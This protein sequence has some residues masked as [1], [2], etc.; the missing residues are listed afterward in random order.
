[1]AVAG[2]SVEVLVIGMLVVGELGGVANVLTGEIVGIGVNV[3]ADV[4]IISVS[5]LVIALL[6]SR[7]VDVQ[8]DTVFDALPDMLADVTIAVVPG[9]GVDVLIDA[10]KNVFEA[11]TIA[12]ELAM[13]APWEELGC[14]SAFA[15][16]PV[17]ALSCD[18][19]LQTRM[20][21][22]QVC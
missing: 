15:R 18:R 9:F 21:S 17:A 12:S 5:K 16:A 3:A 22:Y 7:S 6:L 11:V 1:M 8:S 2:I 19:V 20:P 4:E 14:W 13:P 10:K